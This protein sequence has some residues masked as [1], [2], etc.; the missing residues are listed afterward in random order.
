MSPGWFAPA[1]EP[2]AVPQLVP[3]ITPSSVDSTSAPSLPADD[4]SIFPTGSLP[5]FAHIVAWRSSALAAWDSVLN[6]FQGTHTSRKLSP[7]VL[8]SHSA[9]P[10]R[11]ESP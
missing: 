2:A 6:P 10:A 1:K 9:L 11:W 8:A 5:A 7:I 3:S 4:R